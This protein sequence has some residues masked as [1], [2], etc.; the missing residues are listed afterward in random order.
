VEGQGDT[1][2]L[3][4]AR[5]WIVDALVLVGDVPE[6]VAVLV[7]G[8]RQPEMGADAPV[9]DLHLRLRIVPAV[10]AA[11]SHEPS[12]V[13]EL[14]LDTKQ[15]AVQSREREVVAPEFEHV[16]RFRQ[17]VTQGGL[18]LGLLVVVE[19]LGPELLV[20]DV[21]RRPLTLDLEDSGGRVHSDTSCEGGGFSPRTKRPGREPVGWPSV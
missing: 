7:L 1:T 13:D 4:A 18:E 19:S 21:G 9:D 10:D 2:E 5:R 14:V 15:A 12:P 8:P 20:G 3:V 11:Q 16:V 6:H 17:G